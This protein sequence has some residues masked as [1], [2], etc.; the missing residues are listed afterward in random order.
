MPRE[1]PVTSAVRPL[2]ENRSV[3]IGALPLPSHFSTLCPQ[4]I[5]VACPARRER[6]PAPAQLGRSLAYRKSAFDHA[7]GPGVAAASVFLVAS[8]QHATR[9]SL[10]SP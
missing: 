4:A 7:S 2:S 8:W 3:I 5:P 6:P 9:K 10:D 1:P